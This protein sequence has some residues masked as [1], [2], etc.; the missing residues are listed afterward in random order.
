MTTTTQNTSVARAARVPVTAATPA[1]TKRVRRSAEETKVSRIEREKNLAEKA[2]VRASRFAAMAAKAE[3]RAATATERQKAIAANVTTRKEHVEMQ[4]IDDG[5]AKRLTR[6]I[7]KFMKELGQ[8]N[9]MDFGE[10]TPR[11]TRRGSAMSIRISGHVAGVVKA[12]KHAIGATREAIRF[13][14]NYKLI[15]IKPSM[16]GKKVQ[17]AGEEGKFTVM[18]LKGR[19]H[20]V[21]LQK[22]GNG[23]E[24]R[25]LP[26]DEFKTRM[27]SA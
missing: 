20:D 26:A 3:Q 11:M 4:Q 5:V 12:A 25:Q 6:D 16:L 2:K 13:N 8:K 10:V 14:E 7:A 1:V 24:V 19:A 22:I 27:V 9:N 17:L 23:G 21:V 18:G 15:G